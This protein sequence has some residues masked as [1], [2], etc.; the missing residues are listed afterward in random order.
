VRQK[1]RDKI[2]C[3]TKSAAHGGA[4]VTDS[5]NLFIDTAGRAETTASAAALAGTGGRSAAEE[6]SGAAEK[7]V[8]VR[9]LRDALSQK[10]GIVL[11]QSEA[12]ELHKRYDRGGKGVITIADFKRL[13]RGGGG[14]G[15]GVGDADFGSENGSVLEKMGKEVLARRFALLDVRMAVHDRREGSLRDEI[16]GLRA[17][18]LRASTSRSRPPATLPGAAIPPPLFTG[19]ATITGGVSNGG[20]GGGGV[21]LGGG[22]SRSVTARPDGRR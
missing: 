12:A 15:A 3:R 1:I 22:N 7:G 16:A 20:G 21:G 8:S 2:R 11:T 4:E 19:G 14:G 5:F 18:A 17:A 10:F 9:A 6:G 13:L